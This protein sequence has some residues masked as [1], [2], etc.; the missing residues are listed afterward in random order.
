MAELIGVIVVMMGFGTNV[1]VL[2]DAEPPGVFTTIAPDAPEPIVA[3]I[4]VEEITVNDVDGRPP[5]VT[6]VAPVK[7]VPVIFIIIPGPAIPGKKS[8]IVGGGICVNPASVA[9]PLVVITL[10]APEL[11]TLAGLA[12]IVVA[13]TT[14]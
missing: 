11:P 4:L 9:V 7:P 5:K 14:V 8:V 13:F 3:E 12:V 10:I 6:A 1:N 2:K